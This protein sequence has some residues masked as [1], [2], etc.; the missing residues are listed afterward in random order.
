MS[1]QNPQP[2]NKTSLNA[3]DFQRLAEAYVR[4]EKTEATKPTCTKRI[5]LGLFFDGTN[6]NMGRD[7]P[8][9]GHSNIV[10]LYDA[11]SDNRSEGFFKYYIPGLGTRFPEIGEN[12]ETSSGKAYG[13]GGAARIHWGADPGTQLG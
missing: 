5:W 2:P 10:R 4:T 1:A 11:F 6:N 9:K 8:E 7:K 12:T 13:K 3:R